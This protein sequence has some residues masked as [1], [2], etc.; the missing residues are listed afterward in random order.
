[1]LRGASAQIFGPL[2]SRFAVAKTQRADFWGRIPRQTYVAL[3]RLCL[4]VDARISYATLPLLS[5]PVKS[6]AT[7][8]CWTPNRARF[9]SASIWLT[10]CREASLPTRR[11][12][13]S[14]LPSFRATAESSTKK[15]YRQ[16]AAGIRPL[17]CSRFRQSDEVGFTPSAVAY[18]AVR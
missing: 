15:R 16:S 4:M 6:A 9:F 8:T 7:S 2:L 14:M 17:L 11:I 10:R 18:G 5:L 13:C 1:M 12:T 3:I